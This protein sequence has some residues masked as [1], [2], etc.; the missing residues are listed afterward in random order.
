MHS[1]KSYPELICKYW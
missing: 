1:L